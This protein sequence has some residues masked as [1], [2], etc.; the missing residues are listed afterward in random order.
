MAGG[1]GRRSSGHR[2]AKGRSRR[3]GDYRRPAPPGKG[4]QPPGTGRATRPAGTRPHSDT[5]NQYE[6]RARPAG[7]GFSRIAPEYSG[8]GS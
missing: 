3:A 8:R 4:G 5:D 6:P 2:A 7:P 1:R